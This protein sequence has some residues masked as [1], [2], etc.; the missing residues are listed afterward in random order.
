MP[1]GRLRARLSERR[2]VGGDELAWKY[3][4]TMLREF[5]RRAFH[6]LPDVPMP[7]HVLEWLALMRHYSIPARLV[8]RSYSFYVAAYFA[9]SQYPDSTASA[10][11]WA[12]N[13][14]WL[15]HQY[16]DAFQKNQVD[17]Y[18]KGD[19]RFKEPKDFHQHFVRRRG[20]RAFVAPVNPFRMNQRLNAQQGV[21]FTTFQAYN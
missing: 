8:D 6:F 12:I 19:F 9:L 14:S 21:F 7:L 3:E 1:T 20:V 2:K 10:A 5:T 4:A 16:N 13:T 18:R 17:K 11:V 15:K